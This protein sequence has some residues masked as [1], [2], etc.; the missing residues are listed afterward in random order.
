MRSTRYYVTLRYTLRYTFWTWTTRGRAQCESSA[1]APPDWG[2]WV[3]FS[4]LLACKNDERAT[5]RKSE[6]GRQRERH[7]ERERVCALRFHTQAGSACVRS[8]MR[9]HSL[10]LSHS[11]P[12]SLSLSLSLLHLLSL[13]AYWVDR[14]GKRGVFWRLS[15]CCLC[16]GFIT[17][18]QC[19]LHDEVSRSCKW[20]R[21]R[22]RRKRWLVYA[23][24][25]QWVKGTRQ[26]NSKLIL[27]SDNIAFCA[28]LHE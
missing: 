19:W 12:L 25:L 5:E 15:E 18:T 27:I 22:Q 13:S 4:A 3:D 21:V 1:R 7:R 17:Y 14:P 23:A 9:S 16:L 28:Q 6:G 20:Q 24:V 10:P 26:N 2:G 8:S 11:P